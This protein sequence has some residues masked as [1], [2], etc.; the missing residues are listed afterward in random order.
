M[1]E[2]HEFDRV[3]VADLQIEYVYEEKN[4]G[5][6]QTEI[7]LSIEIQHVTPSA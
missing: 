6:R 1:L 5:R 7:R 3:G 2:L 4:N